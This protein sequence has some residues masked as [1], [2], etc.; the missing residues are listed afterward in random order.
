MS[1]ENSIVRFKLYTTNEIT[2]YRATTFSTK[3]PETLKWIDMYGGRGAFYDIGANIGLFSLYHAVKFNDDVY[4]FE[5]S[6]FNLQL[7]AKNIFINNLTDKIII[8]TN[9]VSERNTIADF[10]LS[11]IEEGSAHSTFK[12]NWNY[13]GEELKIN[14]S[15]KTLGLSL[16]TYI[17]EKLI[18]SPT[19]MKIDVDGIEHLILKGADTVLQDRNLISVLIE[20]HSGYE[21]LKFSVES[22]MIKY[23]FKYDEIGSSGENQI[24]LRL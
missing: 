15:Y 22:Q 21:K 4:A 20:V 24:W 9:P 1:T 10:N 23:G 5:P 12:E 6:L 19:I 16:D 3:E 17:R 11:S 8:I 7:L 14:F 2:L 18:P 13:L